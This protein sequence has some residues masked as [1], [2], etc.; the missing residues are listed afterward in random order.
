MV[1]KDRRTERINHEKNVIVEKK[2][3]SYSQKLKDMGIYK[4]YEEKEDE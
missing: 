3:N 4:K 2:W 1:L